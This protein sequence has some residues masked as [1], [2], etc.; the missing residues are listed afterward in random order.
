MSLARSSAGDPAR[1]LALLWREPSAVPRRG[2]RRGLDLDQLVDAAIALADDEGL[3]AVSMR[4]IAQAMQVAPM[5]VYTYVPGKAELLDLMLDAVYARMP[6]LPTGGETWRQRL[7]GVA[8]ENRALFTAH[9]WVGAVSTLRPT[10]GPGTIGKYEHELA[11][12]DGLGLTDVEMDDCLTYLLTFVQVNVRTA[13]D[14]DA[15]RRETSMDDRAWWEQAGPVL[16]RFIDDRCYP[17]AT[18]VGTAAGISRGSAHDPDHAYRFGLERLLDS[19]AIL[20]DRA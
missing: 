12:L 19:L 6:R 5:T 7:T 2:P 4:R 16:A 3:A 9:P 14:A 17:L 15:T 13:A 20:I 1:T 11:A 18:R 10:L 8:Q